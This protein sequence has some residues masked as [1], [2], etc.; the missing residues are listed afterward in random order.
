VEEERRRGASQFREGR[1]PGEMIEE[2][3]GRGKR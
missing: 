2:R 1:W 3:E